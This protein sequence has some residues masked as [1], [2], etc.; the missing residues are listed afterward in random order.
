MSFAGNNGRY[1]STKYSQQEG[2]SETPSN[3]AFERVKLLQWQT[4]PIIFV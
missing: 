3:Q 2:S 1:L 4:L